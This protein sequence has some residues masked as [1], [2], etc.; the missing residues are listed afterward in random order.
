[1]VRVEPRRDETQFVVVDTGCGI[2]ADSLPHIFDRYWR[3][4][5]TKGGTGLGLYI[6][7]AIVEAHGGRISV[8]STLGAGS[9][10]TFT[11]PAA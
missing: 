11:L 6:A 7:K 3:T 8:E 10:F 1:V 2:E 4:T 5:E 9:T